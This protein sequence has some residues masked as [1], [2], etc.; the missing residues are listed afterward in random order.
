MDKNIQR[1]K[2]TEIDIVSTR[3]R[4][5]MEAIRQATVVPTDKNNQRDYRSE[6]GQL[7]PMG[8]SWAVLKNLTI[9]I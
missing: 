6:T 4:T 1:D 7:G 3:A 9:L 5:R 8:L 2:K